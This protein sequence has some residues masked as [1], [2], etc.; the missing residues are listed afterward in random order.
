[1]RAAAQLAGVSV[2]TISDWCA[3]SAPADLT[4]VA[5]LARAFNVSFSKL[6]LGEE[7]N[8]RLEDV[9]LEELFEAEST[10]EGLFKLTAVKLVRRKK[11]QKGD[12]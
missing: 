11:K 2:S 6:C 10:Y 5:A 3:G 7:E 12:V 4:K 1:M 9:P 8:R